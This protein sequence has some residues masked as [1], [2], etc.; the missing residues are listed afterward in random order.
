MRRDRLA[1]GLLVG[2]ATAMIVAFL[3]GCVYAVIES[4]PEGGVVRVT[5]DALGPMLLIGGV[6]AAVA[7]PIAGI[8]ALVLGFPLFG[9][10]VSR[11][12]SSPLIYIGGGILISLLVAGLM[13]AAHNFTDFLTDDADLRLGMSA[14]LAAG[15]LSALALWFV[16][17]PSQ[18]SRTSQVAP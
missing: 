13:V 10:C 9:F 15:P 5:G 16:V 1:R 2:C 3:A 12:Y 7:A 11:N 4:T 18:S 8:A 17:R 6:A 14:T